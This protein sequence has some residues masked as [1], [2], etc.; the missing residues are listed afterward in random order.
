M[1]YRLIIH[2]SE[3]LF[4]N[5]MTLTGQDTRFDKIPAVFDN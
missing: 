2:L 4:R 3:I 1:I 5:I